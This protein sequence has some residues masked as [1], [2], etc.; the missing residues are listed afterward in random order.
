MQNNPAG[1][2]YFESLNVRLQKRYGH[3]LILINNFIWNR[4]EDRL[5]YLNPSDSAPEKRV[6]SDSRPLRNILTAT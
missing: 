6:S 3:G 4:L 5:A 1:S 2:S